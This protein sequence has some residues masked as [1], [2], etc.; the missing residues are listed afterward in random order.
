MINPCFPHFDMLLD[1]IHHNIVLEVY[2]TAA[3]VTVLL[4]FQKLTYFLDDVLLFHTQFCARS[5]CSN[6]LFQIYFN[7]FVLFACSHGWLCFTSHRQQGHLETA[8]PFTV[9]CKGCE[10]R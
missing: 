6:N 3:A 1:D 2:R 4:L 7:A 10:A 5:T 8:P 9:P